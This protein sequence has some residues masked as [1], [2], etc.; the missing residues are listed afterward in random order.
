M[1]DESRKAVRVGKND[2]KAAD[3]TGEIEKYYLAID[4]VSRRIQPHIPQVHRTVLNQ[5]R[6][7][8]SI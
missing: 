4:S 7:S 5:K 1:I 2:C 8:L 3:V 6:L